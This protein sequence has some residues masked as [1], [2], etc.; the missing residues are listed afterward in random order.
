MKILKVNQM[1]RNPDEPHQDA[2]RRKLLATLHIAKKDMGWTDDYYRSLLESCFGL[3]TSAA[4]SDVQLQALIAAIRNRGWKPKQ[5]AG[6][7]DE[8]IL[9]FRAR[10]NV[11][12]AQIPNGPERLKGLCKSVCGAESVNWCNDV[13]KM[14]R[15]LAVLGNIYRKEG[16]A[17][18]VSV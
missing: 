10:I 15:L 2:E 4:L 7:V 18:A 17:N 12:A 6:E 1:A 14:K 5:R 11:T 9:A 13:S 8:Q 3:S 16:G